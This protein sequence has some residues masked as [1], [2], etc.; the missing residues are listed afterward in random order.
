MAYCAP[1]SGSLGITMEAIAVAGGV[2]AESRSFY[3]WMAAGFLAVAFGGFIPIYWAKVTAG[4]FHSEHIIHIHVALLFTW[5]C[6][7]FAQAMLIAR[8]RNLYHRTW[9]LA[10]ISLFTAMMCSI[11]VCQEPV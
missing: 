4:T 1:K 6:F 7:F 8:G 11:L 3:V 9:G 2:R 10:G 5:K